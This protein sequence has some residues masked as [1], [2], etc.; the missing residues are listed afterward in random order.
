MGGLGSRAA[1]QLTAAMKS[2]QVEVVGIEPDGAIRAQGIGPEHEAHDLSQLAQL[3]PVAA[4]GAVTASV[5]RLPCRSRHG[6]SGGQPLV[7]GAVQ[8]ARAGHPARTGRSRGSRSSSTAPGR[9]GPGRRRAPGRWPPGRAGTP[10][11]RRSAAAPSNSWRAVRTAC[12][13]AGRGRSHPGPVAR[14]AR[15]RSWMT[16]RSR[17]A[18]RA[19]SAS[20]SCRA[21]RA[22]A[23]SS[24]AVVTVERVCAARSGSE[25]ASAAVELVDGDDAVG[26]EAGFVPIVGHVETGG[27]E[28]LQQVPE[29]D[30][31]AV[32]Q[33]PVEGAERL[34]EQQQPGRGARARASATRC[35]SPPESARDAPVLEARR[36]RRAAAARRPA[37]ALRP[38][39]A[40]RRIARSPRC[41]PRHGGGTA[42]GPGR[43]ARTAAG[44]RAP[45]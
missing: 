26:D 36:D 3:R 37:G 12:L 4:R 28:L 9:V 38:S 30:G 32:V 7:E 44:G 25:S 6:R 23:R 45:R 33:L 22:A 16:E 40:R 18:A 29:V 42:G 1:R 15:V 19:R 5:S 21:R 41:R 20:A 34:V 35:A 8:S 17:P 11:V 2:P 24:S 14:R 31:Q 39:A 27:P 10:P 43:P 13:E